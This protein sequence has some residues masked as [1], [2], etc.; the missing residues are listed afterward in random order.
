MKRLQ[1]KKPNGELISSNTSQD[2]IAFWMGAV[3]ALDAAGYSVI[4]GNENY[5]NEAWKDG[6]LRLVFFETED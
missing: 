4:T 6:E 3:A 2:L 1:F 5:K